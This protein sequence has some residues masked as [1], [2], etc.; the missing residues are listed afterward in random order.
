[1]ADLSV[2]ELFALSTDEMTDKTFEKWQVSLLYKRSNLEGYLDGTTELSNDDVLFDG[3]ETR[4]DKN[5]PVLPTVIRQEAY[6]GNIRY[7]LDPEKSVSISIPYIKQS[8]DHESIIPGYDEFNISSAGLGDV[9]VNYSGLVSR[10]GSKKIT[11]SAGVSIPTGSID[12][13]G[14]T[15][16]EPGDQQLPYTM[17]LGSGTWDFPL[18]L[19]YSQDTASGSWGAN[20]FTKIRVGKNSRDY[21]LGNSFVSSLWKTW[22]VNEI[23]R[24]MVKLVYQDWGHIIGQ[25]DDLLVANPTFPYPAGITNP[26][27]YGGKKI[28]TVAGGDINWRSQTLSVELGF[29]VYQDLNGV[30]P[31]ENLHFS[32][33]LRSQF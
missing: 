30:Q 7:L 14:D 26:N 24:P 27:Y 16:R 2:Q 29:P 6:I 20:V 21:R 1:M 5:F 33:N 11:F 3:N 32:F 8:T 25:D 15:P 9:T 13:K 19:S 4:T 28:T 31:K 18:G 10:W 23:L 12:E 17:Q 22:S